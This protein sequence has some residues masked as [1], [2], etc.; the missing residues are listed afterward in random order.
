MKTCTTL[1]LI[2]TALLISL[3]SSCNNLKPESGSADA[4]T[5]DSGSFQKLIVIEYGKKQDNNYYSTV[6]SYNF[7]EGIFVSKDTLFEKPG[8]LSV[9]LIHQ[10]RYLVSYTGPVFDMITKKVI[11]ES[12]SP[13]HYFREAR[14]DTIIYERGDSRTYYFLDLK[15]LKYTEAA[16]DSYKTNYNTYNSKRGLLFSPDNQKVI[17]VKHIYPDEKHAPYVPTFNIVL[18]TDRE[19]S[20]ARKIHSPSSFTLE[21]SRVS[22]FWL[23]NSSFLFDHHLFYQTTD[24][25]GYHNIEIRKYDFNT[26]SDRLVCRIDSAERTNTSR[27]IFR[28]DAMGQLHYRASDG[29]NYLLDTVRNQVSIDPFFHLNK[30]FSYN[31]PVGT[32]ATIRYQDSILVDNIL[33]Q[34]PVAANHSIA[35]IYRDEGPWPG[36]HKGI[37]IWTRQKNDWIAFDVPWAYSIIGWIVRKLPQ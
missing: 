37:K 5:P 23:D 33:G 29:N 34:E 35:V 25:K 2:C 4:T 12:E 31:S 19:I 36:H 8:N 30:D 24:H 32:G 22:I 6:V 11:W 21:I 16:K 9:S 1:L 26:G 20:L 27:G 18:H 17:S 14:G 13:H 15:N 3:C 7:R 28:R 10:N